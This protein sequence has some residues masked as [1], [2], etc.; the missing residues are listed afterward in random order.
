M[1]SR[2]FVAVS[3]NFLLNDC[4][5]QAIDNRSDAFTKPRSASASCKP[6]SSNNFLQVPSSTFSFVDSPTAA[7]KDTEDHF[8]F[9]SSDCGKFCT[10]LEKILFVRQKWTASFPNLFKNLR[11]WDTYP[12]TLI[13]WSHIPGHIPPPN[14]GELPLLG[15]QESLLTTCWV[16]SFTILTVEARIHHL[17]AT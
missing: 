12:L 3:D 9:K 7:S 15:T 8:T 5:R 11:F 16:S 17:S 1:Y 4:K 2:L 6:Q 10:I 14:K 13:P